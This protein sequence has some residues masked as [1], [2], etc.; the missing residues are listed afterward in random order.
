[1]DTEAE[2]KVDAKSK[3]FLAMAERWGLLHD[4]LGGT[5]AMRRAASKWLPQEP[6]ETDAAYSNRV[7]RS[8]LYGAFGDAVDRVVAK[9][10]SVPVGFLSAEKLDALTRPLFDAIAENAD[11]CGNDLTL[12]ARGVFYDGVV[13][14]LSHILVD[15]PATGGTLSAKAERDLGIRPYFVGIRADQVIGWRHKRDSAGRKILTQVRIYERATEDVGRYGEREIER[16]RVIGEA[17]FEIWER[18]AGK[19]EEFVLKNKGEHSFGG[20][21]LVTFYTAETGFMEAEP[22]LEDVAW[23]NLAHWQ[24]SSDQRNILRFA[25]VGILFG[26]GFTDEEVEKGFAIGPTNMIASTNPDAKLSVVEHSGR[27]IQSGKDDLENLEAKMDALGLRPFLDQKG[28]PTATG[29]LVDEAK[30]FSSILAWIRSLE[31]A[32]RKAFE[33]AA[34]W[35]SLPPPPKEFRVNVFSDFGVSVQTNEAIQNLITMR[36]N[37]ELSRETFLAEVKRRGLL[38]DSVDLDEEEDRI[39][40]EPPPPGAEGFGG[41]AFGGG[42]RNGPGSDA[43]EGGDANGGGNQDGAGDA[44]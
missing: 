22:P 10:F 27:A 7:K 43:N 42:A 33:F 2:A 39:E 40:R 6:K 30:S 23:L 32:L 34:K 29:K 21:P 8:F 36:A 9:P 31:T 16:V 20:V 37:R 1:M 12:F 38:S 25:R 5:R 28:N 19:Q 17:D 26:A 3:A 44:E 4:L 24:S 13:H 14:G 35:R 11:Y 18:I 15:H 41:G